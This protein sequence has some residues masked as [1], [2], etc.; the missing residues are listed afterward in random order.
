MGEIKAH[1]RTAPRRA[2]GK[3]SQQYPQFLGL[4]RDLYYSPCML[5]ILLLFSF[6]FLLRLSIVKGPLKVYTQRLLGSKN[7]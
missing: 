4:L 2:F 5:L 7:T 1:V 3:L 6:Q